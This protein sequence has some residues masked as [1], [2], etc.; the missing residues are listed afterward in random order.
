M[1]FFIGTSGYYYKDWFKIIYK[2]TKNL[3]DYYQKFLN[4]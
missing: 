3:L 2:D 1:K 4:S